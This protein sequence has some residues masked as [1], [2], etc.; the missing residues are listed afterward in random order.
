[1]SVLAQGFAD[2]ALGE[3][4]LADDTLGVDPQQ[5][6]DP[7]PGPFSHLCRVDAA[8]QPGQQAG[9]PQVVGPTGQGRGLLGRSERD[10]ARFDPRA[11][12]GD[13][14]QFT[15]SD[16]A[17]EAAIWRGAEPLKMIA[18]QPGELWMRRHG[19]AV[20]RCAAL[21]LPVLALTPVVGPLAARVGCRVARVQ[22][23]S[24][25]INVTYITSTVLVFWALN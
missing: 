18:Q 4:I 24:E 25:D 14:R 7:V 5:H 8:V 12:V 6:V 15:A 17:E 20:A 22:N 1:M 19:P 13:R 10:L 9:V 21:E 2:A 11:P 3:L 23:C 16:A